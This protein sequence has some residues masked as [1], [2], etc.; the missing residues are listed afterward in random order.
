[1]EYIVYFLLVCVNRQARNRE[2]QNQKTAG[3][4]T[5]QNNKQTNLKRNKQNQITNRKARTERT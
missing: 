3:Q 1:M 4:I 2:K 5:E